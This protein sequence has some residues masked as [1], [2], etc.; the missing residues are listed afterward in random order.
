MDGIDRNGLFH[1]NGLYPISKSVF[2]KYILL[3]ILST[4]SLTAVKIS[5]L[6]VR[7]FGKKW[8]KPHAKPHAN[9][10]QKQQRTHDLT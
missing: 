3:F 9:F 8:Q 4:C 10:T 6:N 5:A 2:M 7:V 1:W